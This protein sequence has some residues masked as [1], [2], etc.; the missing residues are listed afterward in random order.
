MDASV[1]KRL[2][3]A[4]V[5]AALALIFIPMLLKSPDVRSPD[6]ADVPLEIPEEA[7]GDGIKTIDIPLDGPVQVLDAGSP[8][9]PAAD[10]RPAGEPVSRNPP[11]VAETETET[12][13]APADP[14]SVAAG[15]FAVV[16]AVA[17]DGQAQ[18]VLKGLKQ[19]GLPATIQSNGSRFRVRVGPYASRAL[20]EQARLRTTGVV[21]GGT[22]VAMDAVAVS[23]K[24]EAVVAKPPAA[25]APA[26]A[27]PV[28]KPVAETQTAAPKPASAAAGK[29]F[30]VQIGAPGSEQAAIALRDKARAA[31]FNSFIQPVETASGRRYRVRIGPENSREAAQAL[32][33]SVRQKT[34]MDGIVMPHP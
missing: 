19:L 5:L 22:V 30:A 17:D 3:G 20:A 7:D 8:P 23:D 14:L 16:I 4:V 29:G 1:K 33:A 13:A 32:L 31:G 26:A 6:S 18:A 34:G 24:T 15:E 28:G 11:P 2:I 9:M 27:A 21:S 10:S 25:D 12:Q